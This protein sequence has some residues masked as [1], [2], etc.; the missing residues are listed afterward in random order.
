MTRFDSVSDAL[1]TLVEPVEVEPRWDEVLRRAAPDTPIRRRGGVVLVASVAAV[2]VL[3]AAAFA[4][5]LAGRFS[6]WLNGT[7]GRPAPAE[8]QEG[9]AARNGVALAS[10]PAGTKLRLLL[11]EAVDGTSF[12]LLGFRNG[13]AYCLRLVRT[14]LPGARGSNQCLRADELAGHVALVADDVW[15][16]VGKPALSITGVYG[17]AA[18]G[19]RSV[20][21]TRARETT[22][23]RV[24]NNVFLALHGQPAGTVQNHPPAD[25]VFAV[26][27]LLKNGS[28][29]DVPYVVSALGGGILPAGKRPTV[30][31]YFAGTRPGAIP[32]APSRVTAPIVHPR[33]G[34]LDRREAV[35]TP[36]PKQRFVTFS[37]G[38]LI[39]PD[40]ND[41][42]RVGVAVGPARGFTRGHAIKGTW[43]CVVD[44]EALSKGP[45]SAGCGPVF[46]NGPLDVGSWMESPITHFNG[47]AADGIV[48][49]EAFLESGRRVPAALRDNVFSVA[50]PQA[51]LPGEL[52]GYDA[53]GRV[54]GIFKL[55]GNGVAKPCPPVPLTTPIAQLP[56]PERWEQ[57]DLA[58]LTVAGEPIL[59]KTPAQVRAI[60]GP[61]ALV[62]PNAQST[63]GIGIP[64]YRYGGTKQ[65][66][67]GLSVT[68]IKHGSQIAANGLYFQSPSLV[69]AKL[70][71]LLRVQP[72]TLQQQVE[73][74]YG[75][76]YRLSESYGG[77]QLQCSG[78]FRVR[79]SAKGFTFGL[80]PY[81]PSRPYLD[82]QANAG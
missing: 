33:I 50:V 38:R 76:R 32:G 41:P 30:P 21:V 79:G 61:P 8:L 62:R 43:T 28:S 64:E 58:T 54:A 10:F 44:I 14:K 71:H 82:I 18:D 56:A 22:T 69:D 40:P 75:S 1:E 3:A 59:G 77:A 49:V 66:T 16:S 36:L 17:F 7:P 12:D 31:S 20:R 39:Q 9:F 4:T 27:A 19:V 74:T 52:V 15:F 67:L 24:V 81:R 63:N 11:R 65:A 5:G 37:F 23:S 48:R 53:R 35:G 29:R 70:G 26:A 46:T 45:G 68:F 13:D 57:L 78:T 47:L 6:A 55:Q 42:V 51:E 72:A 60:L 2:A 80:N 73:R 25:T 34:W